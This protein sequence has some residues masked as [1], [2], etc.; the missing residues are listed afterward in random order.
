MS[1][2]VSLAVEKTLVRLASRVTQL[3]RFK[4]P[5]TYYSA[6]LHQR[7]HADAKELAQNGRRDDADT[8]D[9]TRRW[10]PIL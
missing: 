7:D 1:L 3:H 6:Q 10:Q 2:T 8:T 9:L 5:G 4:L